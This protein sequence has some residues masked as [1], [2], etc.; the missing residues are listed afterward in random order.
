MADRFEPKQTKFKPRRSRL[1]DL[2]VY[3]TIPEAAKL[4]RRKTES[5][6]RW[7]T[8]AG[9]VVQRGGRPCVPTAHLLAEFPEITQR[10]LLDD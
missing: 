6:R 4:L 1:D 5:A 3:Y 9:L 8:H 2:P 10:L 7:L